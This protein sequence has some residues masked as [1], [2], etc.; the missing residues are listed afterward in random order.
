MKLTKTQLK[1]IY[2]GLENLAE[3]IRDEDPDEQYLGTG[4]TFRDI[5]KVLDELFFKITNESA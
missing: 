5:N 2:K 1:V 3:E 4:E